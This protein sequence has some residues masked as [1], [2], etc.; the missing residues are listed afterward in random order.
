MLDRE[1]R[2]IRGWTGG[3]Q[4]RFLETVRLDRPVNGQRSDLGR[5]GGALGGAT[6]GGTYEPVCQ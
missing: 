4:Q 5:S 1:R 3:E 2:L 6:R